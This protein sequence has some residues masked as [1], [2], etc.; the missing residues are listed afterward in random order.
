MWIPVWCSGV[1]YAG[2]QR[3]QPEVPFH[4]PSCSIVA[5]WNHTRE[6]R[7]QAPGCWLHQVKHASIQQ[8]STGASGK[9]APSR[10]RSLVSG[11]S[12]RFWHSNSNLRIAFSS[13]WWRL[14][15]STQHTVCAFCMRHQRDSQLYFP[16]TYWPA[17][18]VKNSKVSRKYNNFP[19]EKMAWYKVLSKSYT[20]FY[21]L[22]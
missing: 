13:L 1:H 12:Q 10:C 3:S 22:V 5:A 14:C 11:P 9:W 15:H 19:I 21:I 20:K 18:E 2:R 16:T 4:S 7:E 17:C 8:L 6:M